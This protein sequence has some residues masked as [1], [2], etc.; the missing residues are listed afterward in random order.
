M[1]KLDTIVTGIDFSETSHDALTWAARHLAPE[2]EFVLVHAAELPV[3]PSF[4]GETADQKSIADGLRQAILNDTKHLEAELPGVRLTEVIPFGQA[5]R[6]LARI[7][8]ERDADM[9]LVGPHGEDAGLKALLGGTA[10]RI[11]RISSVPVLLA[12]GTPTGPPTRIIA[13]IDDRPA[14]NWVLD[15]ARFLADRFGAS[16]TAFHCLDKRL[17]SRIRLI[18]TPGRI[19]QLEH[20]ARGETQA[21]LASELERYGLPS[22]EDHHEVVVDSPGRA[23]SARSCDGFDMLVIGSHG[24]PVAETMLLGS[25]AKKVIRTTCVPVLMVPNPG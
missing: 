13:A 14:R 3:P 20:Q 11:L 6:E 21:W 10:E 19:E 1:P 12:A 8:D 15:W 5:S 17:F 18:S 22:G 2:G 16:V 24:E 23:I 25:V 9:I 7:A 4:L